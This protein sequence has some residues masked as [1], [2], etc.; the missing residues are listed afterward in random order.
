MP[1]TVDERGGTIRVGLLVALGSV[2]LAIVVSGV[3]ANAIV[4]A[5][6]VGARRDCG[7]VWEPNALTSACA[8]A[9]T[10]RAWSAV[11][12]LGV[13]LVGV[14]AAVVVVG[15]PRA[16]WLRHLVVA[17]AAVGALAIASAVIWS[18]VIDR[19]VGT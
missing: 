2:V 4:S 16:A 10:E 18:G 7:T 17:S 8:A 5:G 12:L 11:G 19:T 6:E 13:A 15:A 14:I 9:L 3:Y 1:S